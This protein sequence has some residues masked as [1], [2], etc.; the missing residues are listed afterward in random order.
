QMQSVASTLATLW[1]FEAAACGSSSPRGS[2]SQRSGGASYVYSDPQNDALLLRLND[3]PPGD[4]YFSGWDPNPIPG[5]AS[6]VT[7]HHPQGD[8]KKVTQGAVLGYSSPGVAGGSQPFIEAQWSRGTTEGGSSG[9][10]LWTTGGSQW[11]FRG[12]LWGGSALCTNMSGT[13]F[14]SRFDLVY[15]AISRHLGAAGGGGGTDYTD[16]WWD[17]SESGWGLNLIQHPSRII[18]GVWYTY[19]ADG[20]R[21]WFVMPDGTWTSSNTYSGPLYSTAGPSLAQSFDASKVRVSPVG[22][23]TL[24][25][26]DANHGTFAF[27]VNGVSGTK[28]ITRQPF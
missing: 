12:A 7:I 26:S 21:T 3:A 6:V 5:G 20:K 2:W 4:A 10:G 28:R 14:Y 19:G 17:P 13:D 23:A 22:H 27:T 24:T 1:G 8:L 9:S 16:L 11:L 25:F 15:P 18:F